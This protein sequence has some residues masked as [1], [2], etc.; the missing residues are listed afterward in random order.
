MNHMNDEIRTILNQVDIHFAAWS[1][2]KT[3]GLPLFCLLSKLYN[4]SSKQLYLSGSVNHS[5]ESL[6][7]L[8][9]LTL[10]IYYTSGQNLQ[11]SYHETRYSRCD[12]NQMWRTLFICFRTNNQGHSLHVAYLKHYLPFIQA[13]KNTNKKD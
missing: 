9:V 7:Q 11:Q 6:S 5:K 13:D 8:H 4:C 1:K 10:S 2:M 12:M 3:M